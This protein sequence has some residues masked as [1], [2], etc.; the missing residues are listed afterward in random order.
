MVFLCFRIFILLYIFF[1]AVFLVNL[2]ALGYN[3]YFH[4]AFTPY[5][6]RQ[7]NQ[8]KKKT[9]H[10]LSKNTKNIGHTK[11]QYFYSK[12]YFVL[13]KRWVFFCSVACQTGPKQWVIVW[14]SACTKVKLRWGA[15]CRRCI[16][17]E[18]GGRLNIVVFWAIIV[19]PYTKTY[20]RYFDLDWVWLGVRRPGSQDIT[21]YGGLAVSGVGDNGDA[22]WY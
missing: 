13:W 22:V 15:R 12:E 16:I 1:V 6:L 10:L 9:V 4:S 20:Y 21:R 7:K 14:L 8:S 18:G 17:R 5:T 19:A 11:H 2:C 3:Y